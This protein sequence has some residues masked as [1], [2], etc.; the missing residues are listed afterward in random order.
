MLIIFFYLTIFYLLRSVKMS[1]MPN[2][3]E[4]KNEA[5]MNVY[6]SDDSESDTEEV[7]FERRQN[8]SAFRKFLYKFLGCMG[9]SSRYDEVY[10]YRTLKNPHRH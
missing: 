1:M 10:G 2:I 3:V 6:G 9:S 4:A 8:E 5:S 7:R